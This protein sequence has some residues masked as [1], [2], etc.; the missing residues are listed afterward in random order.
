MRLGSRALGLALVLG[1]IGAV[2][3]VPAE[4]L[5]WGACDL[6]TREEASTALGVPVPVGSEKAMDLPLQ[7][8][9]IPAQYC[10]YGT[11]VIVARFELGASAESV[12]GQYRQSLASESGYQAVEGVGDEAFIAKGQL[13]AR[14][15]QTGLIIDVGQARG[16]GAKEVEAEKTLAKHAFGRM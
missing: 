1:P 7:G 11:E 4:Y 13:A 8:A 5:A 15:G 2:R 16:G 10:F 3:P 14:K 12:F 9:S 6:V